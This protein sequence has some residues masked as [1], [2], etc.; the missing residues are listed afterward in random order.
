MSCI[1]GETF[2]D[3]AK[4]KNVTIGEGVTRIEPKAF[5][6][7]EE[8]TNVVFRVT[9]LWWVAEGPAESMGLSISKE[10]VETPATVAVRLKDT[11]KNYYWN[12]I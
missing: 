4:L 11:Y 1:G 8:L 7:C 9:E 2:R 12:R 6:G 5:S 3:C 10:I